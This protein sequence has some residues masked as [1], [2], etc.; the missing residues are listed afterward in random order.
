MEI[1]GWKYDFES[2]PSWGDRYFALDDV[3]YE[4]AQQDIAVLLYSICEVRMCY[5][6]GN[7]AI[8]KNKQK[9]ELILNAKVKAFTN[10]KI[11]FSEGGSLAFVQ[12]SH[13]S[14]GW[15]IFIFNFSNRTFSCVDRVSKNM[16]FTIRELEENVFLIDEARIEI[17]QLE[18]LDF[19]EVDAFILA[20]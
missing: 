20:K 14:E 9:P 12:S 15:P 7:L 19:E 5:Y 13:W 18:W 17:N 8:L 2:L 1:K 6:V 10:T 11:M 16:N 4:N 3:L